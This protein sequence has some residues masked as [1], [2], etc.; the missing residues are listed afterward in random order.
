MQFL[1]APRIIIPRSVY[2][3][4]DRAISLALNGT[5]SDM[6]SAESDSIVDFSDTLQ[7]V[8]THSGDSDSPAPLG[9]GKAQAMPQPVL[10]LISTESESESSSD[11]DAV[12]IIESDTVNLNSIGTGSGSTTQFSLVASTGHEVAPG[13][14]SNFMPWATAHLFTPTSPGADSD[15]DDEFFFTKLIAREAA[16]AEELEGKFSFS[17]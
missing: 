4:W 16:K 17:A 5:T 8:P 9:K 12:E 14:Q 15:S 6:D 3:D 1:L 2:T 11:S 13:S 10:E 7:V